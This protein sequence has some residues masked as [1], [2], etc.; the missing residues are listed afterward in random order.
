MQRLYISSPELKD[1]VHMMLAIAF[2]PIDHQDRAYRALM[3]DEPEEF[4][5]IMEYIDRVYLRGIRAQGRRRAV[6]PRFPLT[7]WNQFQ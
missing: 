4:V 1:A 3:E 7:W 5:P 6:P 2:V